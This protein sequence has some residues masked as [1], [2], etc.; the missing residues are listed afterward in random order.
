M[1]AGVPATV[2]CTAVNKVCA[3]GMKALML[4]AQ[5]IMCGMNSVVLVAGMESMSNVPHYLP[6]VRTGKK[7]GDVS[8]VDGMIKDGLWDPYNNQH[9]GN[10]AEKCA[11]HYQI[12]RAEQ[13]TYAIQSF[14]RAAGAVKDMVR[15]ITPVIIRDKKGT[16]VTVSADEG[17]KQLNAAKMQHLK[18]SFQDDGTVTA[19]NA[20]QVRQL[21]F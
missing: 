19:A 2:P 15:E 6:S 14:E 5:S 17:I 1:K 21:N 18:P 9:M 3:S 8:C 13:D 4:G 12:T 20:S 10:F 7:M 11:R 16:A